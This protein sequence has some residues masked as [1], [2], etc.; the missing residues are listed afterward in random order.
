MPEQTC[1][2]KRSVLKQN[3]NR[4][5]IIEL[6]EDNEFIRCNRTEVNN[7]PYLECICIGEFQTQ[8]E[9]WWYIGKA[10]LSSHI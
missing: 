9:R 8:R 6:N 2:E 3:K 1:K 10:L 4:T 5:Q 7:K